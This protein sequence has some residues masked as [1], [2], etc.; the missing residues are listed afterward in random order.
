MS[1]RIN[2]KKQVK[3]IPSRVQIAPKVWYDVVW[4]K[5]IINSKGERL[6]G[7]SN[8]TD[9]VITIQM[10]MPAKLTMETFYHELLHSF[11]EE[12]NLGLTE[13]QVLSMEKTLPY[14]LKVFS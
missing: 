3:T 4:Q 5:E 12:H 10:D 14:I 13:N 9:K 11:S 1:N 7:V 6:C 8:L 2:W